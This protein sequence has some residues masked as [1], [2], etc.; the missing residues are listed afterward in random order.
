MGR[1]WF[2]S[3]VQAS[4]EKTKNLGDCGNPESVS[5]FSKNAEAV[6]FFCN[7]EE[8]R[9]NYLVDVD[10]NRMLDLY[11][12]ISSVPI[13]KSW[14]THPRM[15]LLSVSCGSPDF[16]CSFQYTHPCVLPD[17]SFKGR[18]KEQVIGRGSIIGTLCACSSPIDSSS[19]PHRVSMY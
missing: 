3:P 8:S 9:G 2:T 19:K 11:S 5:V 16:R 12:Q 17:T 15:Y 7:Y 14:D 18:E 6:H 4:S 13:G 1:I 10:G